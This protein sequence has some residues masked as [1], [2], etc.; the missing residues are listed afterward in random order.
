[1]RKARGASSNTT[2]GVKPAVAFEAE[3][4]A[5]ENIEAKVKLIVEVLRTGGTA[6]QFASLPDSQRQFNLWA[7]IDGRGIQLTRNSN[8][9]LRKHAAL[10]LSVK[11]TTEAVKNAR[12]QPTKAANRENRIA[13]LRRDLA[14]HKL[15]REIAERAL[16]KARA[17]TL[18]T[19]KELQ[20]LRSRMESL[21]REAREQR[22]TFVSEAEAL[23]A[24]N[25]RL[26]KALTKITPIKKS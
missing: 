15:I 5:R 26:T 13:S 10:L 17:E 18:Q 22:L 11:E 9:T 6:E 14:M 19:R 20:G 2:N 21:E 24:D 1:M 7:P 12:K 16:V 25:A 3:L 4:A 8:D 23:R